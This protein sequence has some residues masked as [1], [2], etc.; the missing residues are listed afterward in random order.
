MQNVMVSNIKGRTRNLAL[1]GH[2]KNKKFLAAPLPSSA[3]VEHEH[4]SDTS[5][6]PDMPTQPY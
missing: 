5:W 6:K 1:G 4:K 2:C 3:H